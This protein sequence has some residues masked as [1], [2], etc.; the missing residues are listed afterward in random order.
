MVRSR[1]HPRRNVHLG[2]RRSTGWRESNRQ[3]RTAT[4]PVDSTWRKRSSRASRAGAAPDALELVRR[5][6][7]AW[8]V[9]R[10]SGGSSRHVVAVAASGA[11]KRPWDALFRHADVPPSGRHGTCSRFR[12]A[13]PTKMDVRPSR[14]QCGGLSSS[15]PRAIT[16]FRRGVP[17]RPGPVDSGVNCGRPFACVASA[18]HRPAVLCAFGGG[19]RQTRRPPNLALG[20][21][22]PVPN[23][24][25][26]QRRPALRPR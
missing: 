19:R 14:Q 2:G 26:R 5:V 9:A 6:G 11:A 18:C 25:S 10:V 8:R 24:R 13:G 4:A 1:R 3:I 23:H 7:P 12:S 16:V 21:C 20:R 17:A 22:G 15:R